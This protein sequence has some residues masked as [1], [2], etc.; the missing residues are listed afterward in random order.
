M[1]GRKWILTGFGGAI[2]FLFTIEA[3]YYL[4]DSVENND[5]ELDPNFTVRV[6]TFNGANR[7]FQSSLDWIRK[8]PVDILC[9]QEVPSMAG[10]RIFEQFAELGYQYDWRWLRNNQSARIAILVRG[11]LENSKMLEAP[12]MG[13][14]KRRALAVDAIVN[15]RRFRVFCHHLES[16][17]LRGKFEGIYVRA[18]LREQQAAF[19]AEEIDK[20]KGMPVIVAGDFNATPTNRTIRPLRKILDDSWLQGGNKL[21][22]TWKRNRPYFRI[23]AVLH[24]GF[25][26]SANCQ[27][28]PIGE[29]DH[30]AYLVDLI[31]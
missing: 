17:L 14:S 26:G 2:L 25:T 3:L 10:E 4:P 9:L 27:R 8:N 15:G 16:P 5:I 18:S 30:L 21:G 1:I 24:R 12:S 13:R 22:G 7:S 23:D 28:I 19:Y 11:Q 6:M 29:S 20:T 31:L